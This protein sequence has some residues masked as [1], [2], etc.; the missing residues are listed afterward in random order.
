MC[1]RYGASF[2]SCKPDF[3]LVTPAWDRE[4]ETERDRERERERER[5][6]S[7]ILSYCYT[8]RMEGNHCNKN[9]AIS[10]KFSSLVAFW[11]LP[12]QPVLT[13][14]SIWRHFHF[15]DSVL[16]SII[17]INL[18]QQ[19]WYSIHARVTVCWWEYSHSSIMH[20]KGSSVV[21]PM[22]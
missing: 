18:S 17:N 14:S 13:I 1:V 5:D 3:L 9:V 10:T 8:I 7:D 20:A 12:L 21:K 6:H 11:Q 16:H 22:Y 2:V 4:R 19:C 15:S